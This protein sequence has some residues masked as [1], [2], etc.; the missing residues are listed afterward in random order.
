MLFCVCHWHAG[1]YNSALPSS[2]TLPLLL[3]CRRPGNLLCKYIPTLDRI[4][5][6]GGGDSTSGLEGFIK[7]VQRSASDAEFVGAQLDL[8]DVMYW[9]PM[10]MA[11][12]NNGLR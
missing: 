12:I 6:W 7:D 11:A 9:N 3:L 4:D 2:H 10:M 5:S 8:H 1:C